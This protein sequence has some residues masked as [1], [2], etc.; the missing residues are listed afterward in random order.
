MIDN[1]GH[2]GGLIVGAVYGF[3]QISGNVYKDPRKAGSITKYFGIAALGIF[4]AVSVF[5]ILILLGI[6]R[7]PI[8][9][10]VLNQ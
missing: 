10:A 2:L 1:Y 5:S 9:A 3:F 7:I 6:I 8:P 4:I